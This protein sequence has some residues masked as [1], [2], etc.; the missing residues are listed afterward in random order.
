M[1][2][3]PSDY[4]CCEMPQKYKLKEGVNRRS[5]WS[6]ETLQEAMKNYRLGKLERERQNDIIAVLPEIYFVE[7]QPQAL[8]CG[9]C[10]QDALG[11]V[12]NK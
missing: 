2:I 12:N 5:Q 1:V 6:E 9:P 10:P 8:K 4:K 3:F 7:L 11:Q